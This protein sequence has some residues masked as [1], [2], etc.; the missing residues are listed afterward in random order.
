MVEDVIPGEEARVQAV[1]GLKRGRACGPSGIRVEDLKGR[2]WEA[3]REMEPVT[4]RWKLLLRLIQNTVKDG[5]VPE[6]LV[7]ETM[8]FLPKGRGGVS[9]D[10][11]Y[12]GGLEGLRDGCELVSQDECDATQRTPWVQGGEEHD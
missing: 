11:A 2:L 6:E 5:V 1:Q 4:H 7:W 8:V 3:S 10:K 12:R 9:G